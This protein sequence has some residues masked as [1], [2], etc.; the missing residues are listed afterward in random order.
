MVIP[1]EQLDVRRED[2]QIKK[3]FVSNSQT[4]NEMKSRSPFNEFQNLIMLGKSTLLSP[5]MRRVNGVEN[6]W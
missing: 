2:I 3:L 5:R 4:G 1:G 6:P